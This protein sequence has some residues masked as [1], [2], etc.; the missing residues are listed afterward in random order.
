METLR[1]FLKYGKKKP[2]SFFLKSAEHPADAPNMTNSITPHL[3]LAVTSQYS[4]APRATGKKIEQKPP[5]AT[6]TEEQT[7]SPTERASEAKHSSVN[8]LA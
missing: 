8:L 5:Q 7:E 4:E 6:P 1:F 2:I 3:P